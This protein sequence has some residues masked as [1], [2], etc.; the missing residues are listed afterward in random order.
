MACVCITHYTHIRDSG[1]CQTGEVSDSWYGNSLHRLGH[2]PSL[3][4]TGEDVSGV[5]YSRGYRGTHA[6]RRLER[7]K[8]WT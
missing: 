3:L 4:L 5:S 6:H 1:V 8:G 2:I 7:R